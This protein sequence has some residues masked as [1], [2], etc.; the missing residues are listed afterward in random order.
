MIPALLI[1][2]GQESSRSAGFGLRAVWLGFSLKEK[3]SISFARRKTPHP[4]E[5]SRVGSCCLDL[6]SVDSLLFGAFARPGLTHHLL[7]L[8]GNGMSVM[9][10]LSF[11]KL[12]LLMQILSFCPL[13]HPQRLRASQPADFS[14]A[15]LWRGSRERKLDPSLT[16]CPAVIR[17]ASRS[18][19]PRLPV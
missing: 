1:I 2:N 13:I 4:M 6:R 5:S 11:A 19:R 15:A 3:P 16:S 9:A 7:A 18:A 14:E 12:R 10:F 17:S 8:A